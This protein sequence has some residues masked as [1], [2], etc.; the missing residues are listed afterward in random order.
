MC[1]V[2]VYATYIVLTR[3]VTITN[4][5]KYCVLVKPKVIDLEVLAQIEKDNKAQVNRQI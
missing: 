3:Q 1:R 2:R 5:D 4:E